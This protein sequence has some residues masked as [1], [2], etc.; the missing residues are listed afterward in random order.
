MRVCV[1][2]CV[3]VCVRACACAYVYMYVCVCVCI[4]RRY[5]T[6][7]LVVEGGRSLMSNAALAALL[8]VGGR[9]ASL[10]TIYIY[11]YSI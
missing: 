3:C 5:D 2:V 4:C 11:I 8:L 7:S 1:C 10:D 9:A 6:W